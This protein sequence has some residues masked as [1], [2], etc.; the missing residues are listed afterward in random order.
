VLIA[1][2]GGIG[3]GKSTVARAL[4]DRLGLPLH[5]IDDDKRDVG[6]ITPGFDDW[7]HAGVPFPDEFRIAAYER[8]LAAL[9]RLAERHPHVIA[10]ETFHRK[11]IRDPF[12]DRAGALMSGFVLVEVVASDATIRDR[13]ARRATAEVDH[14]AGMDMYRAFLAVSDGHDRTEFV[15]DNDAD[16]DAELDR[17]LAFLSGHL[18]SGEPDDDGW[19]SDG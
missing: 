2:A 4:A 14:L 15:F 13:L 7:V 1:I 16:F 17:C 19:M 5:S 3:V 9:E 8:T 11:A 12:F 6:A 10:E 18:E